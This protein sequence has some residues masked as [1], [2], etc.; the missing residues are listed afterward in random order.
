MGFSIG[1]CVETTLGTGVLVEIRRED[2]V[3]VVRLWRSRGAG[4]A[5][6]YLHPDAV[7]RELPAAVGVRVKT[8][9]GDGVVVGF[10]SG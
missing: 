7:L 9:E 3:H 6:A 4:S 1:T 10:M 2:D 8:P 5:K